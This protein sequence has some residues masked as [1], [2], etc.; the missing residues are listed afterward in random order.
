LGQPGSPWLGAPDTSFKPSIVGGGTGP[1][2]SNVANFFPVANG[3]VVLGSMSTAAIRPDASFE[4]EGYNGPHAQE[5][6]FRWDVAT[7]KLVY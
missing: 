3:V 7:N 1:G 4:Y 6:F 5:G 2:S